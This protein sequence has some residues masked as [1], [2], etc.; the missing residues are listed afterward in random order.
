MIKNIHINDTIDNKNSYV[1]YL[2]NAIEND[3][4][5]NVLN[6]SASK[7]KADKNNILQ[8]LGIKGQQLKHIHKCLNE[9][10]LIQSPNMIHAGCYIR[11]INIDD[12]HN[13]LKN[14]GIVCK[15][16]YCDDNECRI[17]LKNGLRFFN[18]HFSKIVM[19]QKFT[20]QEELLLQVSKIIDKGNI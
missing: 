15:T 16:I 4:N 10:Y 18:I 5:E 2:I 20:E 3:K 11:W 19:F 8:Q 1:H 14:G 7:I 13:I 9:Y 12:N 17:Q 6:V